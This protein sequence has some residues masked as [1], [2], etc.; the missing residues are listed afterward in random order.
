[1][2]QT[3]ILLGIVCILGATA[4]GGLKAFGVEIPTIKGARLVVLFIIGAVL[5]CSGIGIRPKPGPSGPTGISVS[6]NS[7]GRLASDSC[8]VNV[9][10]DG[11]LT[12]TGGSGPV[13]VKL[14]VTWDDGV[15]QYSPPLTVPVQGANTY[16]FSDTWL[17]TGDAGGNFEYVVTSPISDGSTARPFSVTC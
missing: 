13:T 8:P 16:P 11:S 1:M 5:V 3:L 6:T 4:G 17:M 7:V 9:T 15:T 12:T 10:V 14:S 2:Y